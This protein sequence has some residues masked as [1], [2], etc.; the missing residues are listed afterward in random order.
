LPPP[1]TWQAA[2]RTSS[3]NT[4][5]LACVPAGRVGPGLVVWPRGS[6]A[7]TDMSRG[8]RHFRTSGQEVAAFEPRWDQRPGNLR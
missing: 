2:S 1:R 5:E 7:A 8:S 3:S 6:F 4:D